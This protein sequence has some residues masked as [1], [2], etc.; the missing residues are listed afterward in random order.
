[1]KGDVNIIMHDLLMY[2][3]QIDQSVNDSEIDVLHSL[4]STYVKTATILENYSDGYNS[5]SGIFQEV[6]RSKAISNFIKR[7][8]LT[9]YEYD[10]AK[11]K[12]NPV[13]RMLLFLPRLV[14]TVLKIAVMIVGLLISLLPKLIKS[15]VDY[16]RVVLKGDQDGQITLEF[17]LDE[18]WNYIYLYTT[19]IDLA[20][21]FGDYATKEVE[22]NMD[23]FTRGI[24]TLIKNP[25]DYRDKHISINELEKMADEFDEKVYRQWTCTRSEFSYNM[26]RIRSE[27]Q[28]LNKLSNR[29]NKYAQRQ[30]DITLNLTDEE[31]D[32]VRK[33]YK[34]FTKI[35]KKLSE[36]MQHINGLKKKI[37]TEQP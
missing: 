13:K 23:A 20:I 5:E 7:Q 31:R 18:V 4:M 24:I 6:S 17:N 32:C 22:S 35:G 21:T 16:K 8:S 15:F 11:S 27:K 9:E 12:E 29:V 30:D 19:N 1:M 33:F 34:I 2:I 36:F 25:R 37:E 3:D 26:D 14:F 10:Y 28:K